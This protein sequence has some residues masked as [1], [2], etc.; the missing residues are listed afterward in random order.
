[1]GE[2]ANLSSRSRQPPSAATSTTET[3]WLYRDGLSKITV[4][5]PLAPPPPPVAFMRRGGERRASGAAD[6]RASGRDR[7]RREAAGPLAA[8][9][10]RRT[11]LTRAAMPAR[12]GPGDG[13]QRDA[14]AEPARTV[15][16]PRRRMR[17]G[18]VCA[19][20]R[21]WRARH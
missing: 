3:C 17:G 19:S 15:R 20:A 14:A 13:G 6:G 12:A 16:L 1:M 8:I 21:G 10:T 4:G 7:N 18:A 11:V 9:A 5:M 2:L